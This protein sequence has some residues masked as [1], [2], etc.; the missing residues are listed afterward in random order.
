MRRLIVLGLALIMASG[1]VIAGCNKGNTEADM[2]S[3]TDAAKAEMK[4]MVNEVYYL[5]REIAKIDRK[6]SK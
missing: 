2:K 1:L 5:N 4:Q 3:A 6:L